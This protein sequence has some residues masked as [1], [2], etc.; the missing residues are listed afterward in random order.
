VDC[1]L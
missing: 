1:H